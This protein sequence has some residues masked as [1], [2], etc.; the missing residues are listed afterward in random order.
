MQHNVQLEE[1]YCVSETGFK[2]VAVG[3]K[4]ASISKGSESLK[5]CISTSLC[6]RCTKFVQDLPEGVLYTN[7]V[8]L[9][10]YIL[11]CG[12]HGNQHNLK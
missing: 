2:L 10:F 9:G 4:I 6:H 3:P 11:L 1:T 8:L 12:N 7:T 5:G